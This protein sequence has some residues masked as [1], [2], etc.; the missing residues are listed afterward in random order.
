[1]RPSSL[2]PQVLGL[3]RPAPL[4][5]LVMARRNAGFIRQA[6]EWPAVLIMEEMGTPGEGN[7]AYKRAVLRGM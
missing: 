3:P 1:L 5:G 4:S 2:L 7:P 6:G